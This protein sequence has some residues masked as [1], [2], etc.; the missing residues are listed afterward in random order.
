MHLDHLAV[1]GESLD[2]AAA[3]LEASLGLPLQPGGAH[4]RF[5]THNRLLGLED[6]LYLEAIAI[7]PNAP[8]PD[9][10]RWFDLDRL[11]GAPHLRTWIARVDDLDATLTRHPDAG[12]SL[13]L[14]RGDLR[15]R[16]AVPPSGVLPFDNLFPALIEW[17]GT[18]HPAQ[19]LAPSGAR[20]SR[21]IVTHPEAAALRAALFDLTDP[22]VVIEPGAP[23]LRAEIATPHG[24]RVLA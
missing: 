1:A 3:H 18:A 11:Q 5:G 22:R 7:D 10:P 12:E 4:A 17:Q 2:A 24:L 14:E 16:M 9:G 20:L 13:A 15:W 21:L 8:A 23:A 19:R 6:G